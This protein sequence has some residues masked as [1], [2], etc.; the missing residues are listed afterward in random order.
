MITS[1]ARRERRFGILSNSIRY[2]YHKRCNLPGRQF[3]DIVP[4]PWRGRFLPVLDRLQKVGLFGLQDTDQ[5]V[6]D[7]LG[8]KIRE[9]LKSFFPTR[10]A[11]SIRRISSVA[12]L[13]SLNTY[14]LPPSIGS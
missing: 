12:R 1:I 3:E 13:T 7:V 9:D 6:T 8:G 5:G 14:S 4:D 10:S 11:L 2:V